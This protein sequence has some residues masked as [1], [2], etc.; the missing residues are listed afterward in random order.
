MNYKLEELTPEEEED[1]KN[2]FEIDKYSPE[3]WVAKWSD[4]LLA[5]D[6]RKFDI[7]DPDLKQWIDKAF[8]IIDNVDLSELRK[9]QLPKKDQ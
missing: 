3:Y 9:E 5:G 6:P 1:L 8:D 2:Y 4:L 7:K